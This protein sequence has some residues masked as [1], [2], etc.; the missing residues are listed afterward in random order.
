MNL[1]AGAVAV[2]LV[3]ATA[4]A[5]ATPVRGDDEAPPASIRI[6]VKNW[7]ADVDL[8]GP[9]TAYAL[10]GGHAAATHVRVDIT[11]PSSGMH[12]YYGRLTAPDAPGGE[13][14]LYCGIEYMRVDSVQRCGFDVPMSAGI[15]RL[16]FDLQSASWRGIV[17]ADGTVTAGRLGQVAVLEAALPYRNWALMPAQHPLTIRGENTSAVR[18]RIMNTGDLPF[19]VRDSCQPDSTVWPYQ[20]LLCPVRAPGPVYALAGNYA[21]PAVLEDPTGAVTAVT[22][23]G[24]LRA[25]GLATV[26]PASARPPRGEGL[27][28]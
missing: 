6:T 3:S 19:R 10:A 20:Q 14:K 21:V 13:L 2:L 26:V 11:P 25:T 12:G 5:P 28:R 1:V 22:V 9:D 7:G 27:H 24:R 8:A 4:A 15:N 18:Y 23:E 17:S 16:R